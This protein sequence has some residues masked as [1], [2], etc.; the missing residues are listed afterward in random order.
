MAAEPAGP[1]LSEPQRL[2]NVF[3]APSKTFEDLKRN[4]KWWVPWLL[5]SV[6]SIAFFVMIDQ[7]VGFEQVAQHMVASNSRLQQAPPAQQEQAVKFTALSLKIGGY[8]SP[9]FILLY[10]VIIA[11]VLMA[12]FNFGMDAQVPFGRSLAIVLY[13]WVAGLIGTVLAILGLAFGNPEGFRMENPVGTNPAY[14]LDMASTSKFVY[15]MLTAFDIITIWMIALMGIGFA[16]NAKKK[17]STGA[18]IGVVASWYFL[19]KLGSAGLAALR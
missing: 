15:T 18:A 8:A 3:I 9:L 14:Y 12:T 16:V 7:K 10:S 4:S 19:Y 2:I 17:I 13:S 1:G 11:A 6:F 5:I